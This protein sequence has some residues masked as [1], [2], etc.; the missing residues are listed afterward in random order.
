MGSN[1]LIEVHHFLFDVVIFFLFIFF[2]SR[3]YRAYFNNGHLHFWQGMTISFIVYLPASVIFA[4]S[5][6]L[7]FELD[8]SF[9]DTYKLEMTAYLENQKENLPEGMTDDVY[10]EKIEEIPDIT[11]GSL[12]ISSWLKKLITGLFISPVISIFSRKKP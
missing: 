7:L 11:A 4:F 10:K 8:G 1:P 3:E 5:L 2:A 12:I 6:L 9:L